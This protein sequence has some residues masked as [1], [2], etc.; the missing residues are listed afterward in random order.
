[1]IDEAWIRADTPIDDADY[2]ICGPRPMLRS[3]IT[4]L[5]MSGLPADR[6]HYE[7]FGPADELLAA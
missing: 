6:I 7:F 1:L 3:L 4:A 2:F 5:S